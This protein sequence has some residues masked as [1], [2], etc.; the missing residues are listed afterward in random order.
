MKT[1][2]LAET[3]FAGAIKAA[4]LSEWTGRPISLKNGD[5]W[6]SFFGATNFTGKQVNQRSVLQLAAAWACI[7]LIAETMGTIPLSLY[8]DGPD[9]APV[10]A[11]DHPVHTLIATSPNARMSPTV[12]WECVLG[13]LMLDGNA[14]VEKQYLGQKLVAIDFLVPQFVTYKKLRGGAREWYYNDPDTNSP[15]TI[16]A[17]RMW[18]IPGFSLNGIDGVSTVSYGANVFGQAQA[19]DEASADTFKRA[20]KSPGLVTMDTLLSPE[21][22]TDIRR[23]VKEVAD[24]GQFMV[25]E[26]GAAFQQLMM[27]PLD[28]E[29]LSSRMFNIEEICRWFRVQPALIGHGSKDSNWGTGLEEKMSWF[30]TL[31]LRP[32]AK[33][34]EDGI[35]KDLLLPS[36]RGTYSAKFGLEGLLRGDSAARAEFFSKMV[37]NGI[38]TRDDCRKLENLPLMGG[39][40]NVLTVQSAMLPID[41]LGELLKA[42]QAPVGSQ[43]NES[44]KF[45]IQLLERAQK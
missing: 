4:D 3:F 28:A 6:S 9:G 30:V 16:P 20:L 21:Q 45:L 18:H 40:A 41:M 25:L 7:K 26:K 44:A 33:R 10:A 1:K 37:N 2:T 22:R 42:A 39:N 8:R 32:W 34:I 29:L 11:T 13:S 17:D 14:Y 43:Q 19:T 36:E 31:T 15:R 23:H 5:F 35:R 38:Y 12:F 24:N 27:K